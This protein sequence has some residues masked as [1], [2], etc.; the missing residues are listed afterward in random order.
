MK[1][2]GLLI[3]FLNEWAEVFYYRADFKGFTELFLEHQEMAESLSDRLLLGI[4]YG[5]LCITLFCTGKADKNLTNLPSRPLN[6]VKRPGT[7]PPLAWPT[8]ILPGAA[9]N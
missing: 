9:L 3:D 1:K 7:M 4:F 8:P 6:W 2:N 5:W